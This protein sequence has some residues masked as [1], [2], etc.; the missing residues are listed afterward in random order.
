MDPVKVWA[1][2]ATPDRW[3]M[4]GLISMAGLVAGFFALYQFPPAKPTT[5]VETLSQSLG[6]PVVAV[7]TTDQNQAGTSSSGEF[8]SA[9]A[10]TLFV[11][12]K[13]FLIAIAVVIVGFALIDSSIRESFLQNPFD[14]VARIFRVFFGYA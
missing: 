10:N 8:Y 13:Y 4:V 3:A 5:S 9:L 7:L 14:G 12:S 6:I 1:V 11:I 2:N